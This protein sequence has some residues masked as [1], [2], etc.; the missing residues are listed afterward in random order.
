MAERSKAM[1]SKTI[2]DMSLTWVRILPYL[3]KLFF[4]DMR[5]L[6]KLSSI[7]DQ[8][9]ENYVEP[10]LVLANGQVYTNMEEYPWIVA[11]Y[12]VSSTFS[13][14]LHYSTNVDKIYLHGKPYDGTVFDTSGDY[15][16]IIFL[17]NNTYIENYAFY[18]TYLSSITI[19]NS[20][21]EI[22][23]YAFGFC[24]RL[25]SVTIGNRVTSIEDYAF[26]GCRGLSSVIIPSSV[27]NVGLS[28][29]Y[30]CNSLTSITCLATTPPTLGTN[31]FYST[32]NCPIYVPSG[33]VDAYKSSWSTYSSRI[34]SI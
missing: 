10:S 26:G 22:R 31:V 2:R 27:T 23:N 32:N 34:Q 8:N 18:S 5:N 20:V 17:K 21:T 29:F 1:V 25:T 14:I 19:P 9:I 24:T 15:K 33:S 30:N 3:L 16:V 28:A 12:N 7:G 6:R 4:F 11:E 13:E